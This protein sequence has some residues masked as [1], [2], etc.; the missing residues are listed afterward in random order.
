[1][2]VHS[3]YKI[4]KMLI[5]LRKNLVQFCFEPLVTFTVTVKGKCFIFFVINDKV[6]LGKLFS[7]YY[8]YDFLHRINLLQ[9]W[10]FS[11]FLR[12]VNFVWV[13]HAFAVHKNVEVYACIC[14]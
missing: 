8:T 14:I 11:V 2:Y 4:M 9:H 7:L 13:K 5:F 10:Q 1:M 3:T 6:S 12:R